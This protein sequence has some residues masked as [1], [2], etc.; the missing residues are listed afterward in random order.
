MMFHNR[1]LSGLDPLCRV[2]RPRLF[3]ICSMRF[4]VVPA[5]LLAVF[6]I[7]GVP[8]HASRDLGPA[9]LPLPLTAFAPE[10]SLRARAAS[11]L[12]N[13]TPYFE[14][15]RGQMDARVKFYSQA[16]GY[17]LFLTASEAVLTFAGGTTDKKR[18][19]RRTEVVRLKLCDARPNPEIIGAEALSSWSSYFRGSDSTSWRTG[20][21]HYR[22]VRY[23]G[24]YPGIDM[25]YYGS[26]PRLEYDFVVSPGADPDHIRMRFSGA[27][28]VELGAGGDLLVQV[29]STLLRQSRPIVYQQV[30]TAAGIRRVPVEARYRLQRKEVTFELGAY[31]RRRELVIDP[32]LVYSTLFGGLSL[33]EIVSVAV[34]AEGNLIVAGNTTSPEFPITGNAFTGD[35]Q[36]QADV[37]VAKLRP[38]ANDPAA[39]L[40]SSYLGGSSA[41]LLNSM[42]IDRLGFVYLAGETGSANWPLAGYA[43]QTQSRGDRDGFVAV[44]DLRAGGEGSLL[45]SSFLG[46]DRVDVAT[47]VV[48]SAGGIFYVAG[49][50]ASLN[51]PTRDA[52]QDSVRGGWDGFFARVD[53]NREG[54]GSLTYCS[55]LGGDSTDVLTAISLEGPDRLVL[56]G[57]SMSEDYPITFGAFQP[58]MRGKGD[59]VV[60]RVDLSKPGLDALT[61]GSYFGGS[62]LDV[63]TA[64]ALTSNGTLFV[65]GY[66]LSNDFPVV[67]GYQAARAGGAD[68]FFS[69]IGLNQPG[70]PAVTYST[71]LGGGDTEVPYSLAVHPDGGVYITGYTLSADF[72]IAGD[73]LARRY[74]GAGDGFLVS[75]DPNATVPLQHS[76]YFGGDSIDVA[77]GLAIDSAGLVYLAGRT[78]SRDYPVTEGAF[79]PRVFGLSNGF[80][81]KL[82]QK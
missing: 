74:N 61:F 45:Y 78:Q 62:D 1:K 54:Q 42:A 60:S 44:L 65:T 68:V 59:G 69:R 43:F 67:G 29:G 56:A 37:F 18:S 49:Y 71:F 22:Q 81:T 26:G 7:H 75:I 79:Q 20:I 11:L 15:N 34:D 10:T 14:P 32:V 33:D 17:S 55:Y 52:L 77:F 19:A 40:Y 2:P 46:G 48:P 13:R 70:G 47:A 3:N 63:L 39:L 51:F 27:D 30:A 9:S 6:S 41:D 8:A 36:G 35:R 38:S 24:V 23:R 80:V 16:P 21:P 73:P 28:K 72:P 57:Y 31:D 12:G 82:Q 58:A 53:Q 50:T 76:G 4:P 25:V 64:A 66:T 5:A